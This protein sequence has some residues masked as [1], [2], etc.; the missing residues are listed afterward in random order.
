MDVEF[1]IASP[2]DTPR[3]TL[4]YGGMWAG[5]RIPEYQDLLLLQQPGD[6]AYCVV[7]YPRPRTEAPPT[8]TRLA[9][10][11]I[12]KVSGT[13]GTDYAFL[14]VETR[15][16]E[17][18]D[19]RFAGTAAAVQQRQDATTLSLAAAGEAR[20]AEF[21]LAGP[22]A[23]SLRISPAELTVVLPTDSPGGEFQITA[24]G[25]WRLGPGTAGVTLDGPADGVHRLTVPAGRRTVSLQR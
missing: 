8:F 15:T 23:A 7:A 25:T 19:I 6:G 4:R 14:A 9:D 24:P 12:L 18:E 13:N 3:H 22:A 21:G 16:A 2:P 5:N 1:F 20:A 11:T 17:A 10:G